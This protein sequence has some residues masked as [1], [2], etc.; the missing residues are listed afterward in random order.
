MQKRR[1]PKTTR[2]SGACS[3]WNSGLPRTILTCAADK[4]RRPLAAKPAT[5]YITR[6][7]PASFRRPRAGPLSSGGLSHC[8]KRWRTEAP[9]TQN[10]G[11]ARIRATQENKWHPPTPTRRRARILPR[12]STKAMAKTK[13]SRGRSSRAVSSRSKKTLPSSISV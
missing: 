2:A 7:N 5:C 12:F 3:Q 11:A 8:G 10:P 9:P 4:T 13:L 6:L 1:S